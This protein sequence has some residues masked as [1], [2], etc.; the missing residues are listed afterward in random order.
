MKTKKRV[1][2][3]G[4]A[5]PHQPDRCTGQQLVQGL[6]E[7]GHDA[8]FFGCFYL[9]PMNFLGAKECQSLDNWDLVI[10][11][12]MNDGMPGYETLFKYY[13]FQNVPKIYWDFDISYNEQYAWHRAGAY[14][15]DG[16]LV[17][18]KFYVDKFASRFNKPSVHMPYACS[19]VIHRRK[20]EIQK[21]DRIGFI[22][23][24]TAERE[25]LKDLVKCQTGIFADDMVNAT[26]A[27]Y[28]MIH[29]NQVACRGMVP[30]RPWETTGCGTSL[31]MDIDSYDDFKDFIPSETNGAVRVFESLDHLQEIIKQVNSLDK[32][33]LDSLATA[34][35][36][37]MSYMHQN[38]TYKNRA[39]SIIDWCI[40]HKII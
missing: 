21:T 3:T 32:Q 9:Q 14:Q 24:I 20:P 7:A 18:N 2:V 39:E 6:K 8:H 11:T 30:C 19:P 38:H 23:S 33:S 10:S 27:L 4:R 17:A 16:Y 36:Q 13:K 40:N 37:L 35:E 28:V 15:Y 26:N 31:L 5:I 25:F 12:E 34:S 1:L 29:I 22:G